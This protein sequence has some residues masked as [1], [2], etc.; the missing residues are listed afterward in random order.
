MFGMQN[1]FFPNVGCPKRD[2]LLFGPAHAK[3]AVLHVEIKYQCF[4]WPMK[5]SESKY[6]FLESTW[7]LVCGSSPTW[8]NCPAGCPRIESHFGMSKDR[9]DTLE[10]DILAGSSETIGECWFCSARPRWPR[11]KKTN[12]TRKTNRV[13]FHSTLGKTFSIFLRHASNRCTKLNQRFT[14]TRG[15]F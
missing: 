12:P 10:F 4:V 3:I 8:D 1:G 9:S 14:I 2:S 6:I 11:S 7:N 13:K 5:N 15:Q